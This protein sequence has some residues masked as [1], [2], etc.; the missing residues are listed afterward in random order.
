MGI[1]NKLQCPR[2]Y[3]LGRIVEFIKVSKDGSNIGKFVGDNI[4][5]QQYPC[6]DCK[7]KGYLSE[8]KL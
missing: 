1:K 4:R 3:G 7:G 8:D 2:C 6:P 5:R